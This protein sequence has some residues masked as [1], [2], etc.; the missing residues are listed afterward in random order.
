VLRQAATETLRFDPPIHNTRRI[1]L[2]DTAICGID[3]RQGEAVLA[4]LAAANRDAS[5]FNDPDCF[6]WTR[7]EKDSKHLAFGTGIH[8]CVAHHLSVQ[9][10]AE[11]LWQLFDCCESVELLEEPL[12][13]EPA[14]NARL[15]KRMRIHL[16]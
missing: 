1:A 8:E 12:E 14:V 13:Y 5:V 6:D 11:A 7:D 3:V 10:T 9:M 15:A 2:R 4:V 16:R